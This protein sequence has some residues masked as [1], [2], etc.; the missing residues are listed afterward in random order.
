MQLIKFWFFIFKFFSFSFQLLEVIN[1]TLSCW[2]NNVDRV[3]INENK[4]IEC[5][6]PEFYERL[7]A[8]EK[9]DILISV[10]LFLNTFDPDELNKAIDKSI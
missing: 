7:N 4:L 3:K 10:K 5:R 6:H 2:L 1:N 9:N 8:S